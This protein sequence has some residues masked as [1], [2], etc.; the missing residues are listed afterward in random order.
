[1][2]G[3]VF[4]ILSALSLLLCVATALLWPRS[5]SISDALFIDLP[6]FGRP[7]A[8]DTFSIVSGKGGVRF[9]FDRRA[10]WELGTRKPTRGSHRQSYSYGSFP[11]HYPWE[12]NRT[13]V[14]SLGFE[15][16]TAAE[17]IS[18]T[19][20]GSGVI[21][22]FNVVLPDAALLAAASLLPALCV[23]R[24]YRRRKCR[25][26]SAFACPV[27]GYDLRATPE[28]CPECGAARSASQ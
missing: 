12:L 2:K 24:W 3:R 19:S 15:V 26:R 17:P 7:L 16:S 13:L 8:D 6:Q 25:L 21:Y 27:C 11:P 1:M 14:R 20:V 4:T 10:A 22:Q 9:S 28:R 18:P 23:W 5:Y